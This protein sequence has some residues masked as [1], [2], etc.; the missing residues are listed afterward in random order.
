MNERKVF[1]DWQRDHAGKRAGSDGARR[2]QNAL[3]RGDISKLNAAGLRRLDNA[4]NDA[5][6]LKEPVQKLAMKAAIAGTGGNETHIPQVMNGEHSLLRERI[7]VG[8]HGNERFA[9]D[10]F[11]S[12]ARDRQLGNHEQCIDGAIRKT[13]ELLLGCQFLHLELEF[14]VRLRKSANDLGKENIL[15][16]WAAANAQK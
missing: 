7:L 11:E 14:R 16:N 10:E 4:R 12:H 2:E 3:I 8:D 5:E 15:A 1:F 9:V 13:D 6:R